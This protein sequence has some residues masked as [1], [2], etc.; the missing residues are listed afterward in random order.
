[1]STTVS[2]QFHVSDPRDSTVAVD[3]RDSTV[4]VD[5][6]DSTAS[7]DDRLTALFPP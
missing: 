2:Q 7:E 5:P 3:P 1:M 6:R 4:A